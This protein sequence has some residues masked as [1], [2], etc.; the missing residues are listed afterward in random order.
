MSIAD[1]YIGWYA[2]TRSGED[3]NPVSTGENRHSIALADA[4]DAEATHVGYWNGNEW[5]DVEPVES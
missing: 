5:E 1:R 3:W 2:L 4:I